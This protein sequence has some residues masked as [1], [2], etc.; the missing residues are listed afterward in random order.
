MK[1]LDFKGLRCPMPVV[2][3]GKAFKE[4]AVGEEVR[5]LAD[6]KGFAPDVR[7]WCEKT[8]QKLVELDETNTANLVAVIRKEK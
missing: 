3:L 6:D 2:K 8:G 7:A 1:E 4:L 5:V